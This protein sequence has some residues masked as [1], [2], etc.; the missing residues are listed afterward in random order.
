MPL[1]DQQRLDAYTGLGGYAS[2]AYL[3]QHVRESAE[4][5]SR[6]QRLARYINWPRKIIDAYRGTLFAHPAQRS[7][8]AAPWQAL[9]VNADRRGGQIDDVMRRVDLLAKLL[10][11]CYV[12]VD[13]PRGVSQTRADDLARQPYIVLRKPS[14][15]GFDDTGFALPPLTVRQHVV[16]AARP[17]DGYLFDI[18]AVGLAEQ[19]SDLRNTIGRRMCLTASSYAAWSSPKLLML[20]PT[21]ILPSSPPLP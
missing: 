7:G 6:R 14:D 9:Q 3:V 21:L 15:M 12:V 4:K 20:L 17:R 13:R 1:T 2:G 18:P 8:E 5:Y 16:S 19:R 11:T 10:G